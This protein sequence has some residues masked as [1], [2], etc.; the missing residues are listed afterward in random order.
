L[1][2]TPNGRLVD[3]RS[4]STVP[5]FPFVATQQGQKKYLLMNLK[6]ALD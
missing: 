1:P 2:S 6:D 3:W 4:L 5:T